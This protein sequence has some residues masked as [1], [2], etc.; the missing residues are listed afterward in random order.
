MSI[1]AG[2]KVYGHAAFAS[3]KSLREAGVI[4]FANMLALKNMISPGK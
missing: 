4:P 3:S 2:M 1:C